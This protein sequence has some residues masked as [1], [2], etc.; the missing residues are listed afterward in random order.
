L[1]SFD[2]EVFAQRVLAVERH[3]ARV[4]QKLPDSPEK[5]TPSS[6]ESDAVILHLW[7]AVQ[8]TID[9]SMAL[10]V[11]SGLGIPQTYRESFETLA[12]ARMLDPDLAERLA[13]AAGFRNVIAHAYEGLDLARIYEAAR[14]G[15]ADLRAFLRVVRDH[16]SGDGTPTT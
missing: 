15:P 16:T 2:T 9:L 10:C 8:I 4:A 13:R 6:D 1:R 7:M 3:L 14:H 11:R 12:R 5:L